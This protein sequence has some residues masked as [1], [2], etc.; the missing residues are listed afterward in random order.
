MLNLLL[1]YY[2]LDFDI[3]LNDQLSMQCLQKNI[4]E[5]DERTGCNPCKK[6]VHHKHNELSD[7]GFKYLQN[8]I[9]C[10]ALNIHLKFFHFAQTK[11]SK[12]I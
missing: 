2:F 8:N 7:F 4:L 12:Q 9:S 11:K 5:N 3:F 6:C 10:I 1:P